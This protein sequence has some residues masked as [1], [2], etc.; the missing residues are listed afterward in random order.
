MTLTVRKR[1][2]KE[3]RIEGPVV[4]EDGN[5]QLGRVEETVIKVGR[6]SHRPSGVGKGVEVDG[7]YE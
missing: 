5:V 1:T 7:E 4:R 6:H 2:L 3:E